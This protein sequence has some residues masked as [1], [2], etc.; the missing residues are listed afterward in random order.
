MAIIHQ[1][2]Y[3]SND[4]KRIEFG[5][6][7]RTLALDLFRSYAAD[8]ARIKLN[9]D[10]DN[11]M[12]DINTAIPLGLIINELISNSL[13]YAFPATESRGSANGTFAS[14][15]GETG[16]LTVQFNFENF[17]YSLVISD[18]GIG[19]PDGFDYEKSD[20]FGLMLVYSLYDQ[21]G[22]KIE[23]D[24]NEGVKLKISFEEQY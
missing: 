3:Q 11:V 14:P 9:I 21:I 13:K 20:S 19:L 17:K 24:M 12:L 16:K 15:D 8:P 5:D 2:L 6:Y 23:L 10:V 7:I 22:A 4:L 1:R 18:D